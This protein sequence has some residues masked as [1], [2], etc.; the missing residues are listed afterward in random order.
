MLTPDIAS[1][2]SQRP[3]EPSA[4][5][6]AGAS[7]QE[8]SRI[9]D[10][11]SRDDPRAAAPRPEKDAPRPT[12]VQHAAA[13]DGR[14]RAVAAERGRS[15]SATDDR[16]PVTSAGESDAADESAAATPAAERAPAAQ[17][18]DA[19]QD[20]GE[21]CASDPAIADATTAAAAPSAMP[22][23]VPQPIAA[24]PE[25]T[26]AD[27]LAAG[28]T[29]AQP[30]AVDAASPADPA[31]P[32]S[33]PAGVPV[34]TTPARA[35]RHEADQP[36]GN[37]APQ[38]AQRDEAP[39]ARGNAAA[40]RVDETRGERS[41][42]AAAVAATQA[43]PI[44]P[45]ARNKGEVISAAAVAAAAAMSG[46]PSSADA[47]AASQQPTPANRA[48]I[49]TT[50]QVT[51]STA[52]APLFAPDAATLAAVQAAAVPETP[53]APAIP[54]S[55]PVAAAVPGD[56]TVSE[57]LP[58]PAAG[59]ASAPGEAA[60]SAT[61][62]A[63]PPIAQGAQPNG[64]SPA[65]VAG[66]TSEGRTAS[67]ATENAAA[68]ANAAADRSESFADALRGS[69]QRDDAG[70]SAAP[71]SAQSAD[72]ALVPFT[73]P[74]RTA[75]A[76]S[77]PANAVRTARAASVPVAAQVAVHLSKA[78]GDGVGRINIQLSPVE[79]GRI[80]VRLDIGNDGHVMAVFN[81]DRPQTADLLQRDA[82]E[83]SRALQD[84]G[85]KTDSGSL[86][87]NL[88]D[89]NRDQNPRFDF[90]TERAE[91]TIDTGERPVALARYAAPGT[92]NG[93]LDI[94]V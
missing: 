34:A 48:S 80:D 16:A 22:A 32:A 17:A 10:S 65:P 55:P 7:D 79:L 30:L 94:R 4:L 93:R 87:F 47:P 75:Q 85:L 91:P 70:F 46:K 26:S 81:V 1:I 18:D 41:P 36:A 12:S 38:A 69:A 15:E 44:D 3:F 82:R 52:R 9:L 71:L 6:S 78:V 62:P 39:V 28:E 56:G 88:R 37:Q 64:N 49:V 90:G 57:T 84:S 83:L 66:S 61:P 50:V 68:A 72:P 13:K 21:D 23:A 29:A 20:G 60:P 92:A 19:H 58:P 5:T 63:N 45:A 43:A 27:L 40:S 25:A 14:T 42:V 73:D 76:Q 24:P 31:L 53:A 11:V 33:E 8:F 77:D 67:G 51:E 89:Q 86:S 35:P 2:V 59:A 74:A 54:A